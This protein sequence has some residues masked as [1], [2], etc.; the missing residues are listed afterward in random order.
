MA[1]VQ[2]FLDCGCAITEDGARHWCPSCSAPL[3][4]RSHQE[5]EKVRA[6][7]RTRLSSWENTLN[8][9]DHL[10][11]IRARAAINEIET[12]LFMLDKVDAG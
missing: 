1:K 11:Q 10:E 7:L 12:V 4:T 6:R 9:G 5:L 2:K 3:P 8:K